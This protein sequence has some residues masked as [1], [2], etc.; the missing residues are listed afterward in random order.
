M[1]PAQHRLTNKKEFQKVYT[2]G[3]SY[4]SGVLVVHVLRGG[5]RLLV[6]VSASKRVGN[7]VVRNRA[8]RLLREAMESLL[9]RIRQDYRIVIIARKRVVEIELGRICGILNRL[10][11]QAG[12]LEAD[13]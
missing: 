7:A 12:V 4:V 3:T 13:V 2:L 5:D 10:L 1:L 6:G 11:V 9:P 8:K